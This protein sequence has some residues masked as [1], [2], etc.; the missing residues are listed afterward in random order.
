MK[1][2][3][4]LIGFGKKVLKGRAKRKRKAAWKRLTQAIAEVVAAY[5]RK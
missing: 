2:R 3:L 1:K 4:D 5:R